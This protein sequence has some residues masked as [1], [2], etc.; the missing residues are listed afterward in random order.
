MYRH[1]PVVV[2]TGLAVAAAAPA[3]AEGAQFGYV[4]TAETT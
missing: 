3:K 4:Y 2:L 1:L